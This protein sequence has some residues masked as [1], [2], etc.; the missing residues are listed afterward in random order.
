L[1]QVYNSRNCHFAA[2]AQDRYGVV[3]GLS[4]KLYGDLPWLVRGEVL[5]DNGRRGRRVVEVL[6]RREVGLGR[7]RDELRVGIV[8]S[9]VVCWDWFAHWNI[10][11]VIR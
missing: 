6:V 5:H 3:I 1:L 7:S 10:F 2:G 4:S 11:G 9:I 8:S